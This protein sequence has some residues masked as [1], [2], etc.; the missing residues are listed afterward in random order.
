M[1]DIIILTLMIVILVISII[2]IKKI[3]HPIILI[4]IIFIFYGYLYDEITINTFDKFE[5]II[6]AII[7]FIM[8]IMSRIILVTI[9]KKNKKKIKDESKKSES[10]IL[11]L[12]ITSGIIFS[13]NMIFIMMGIFFKDFII[14]FK[15]FSNLLLNIGIFNEIIMLIHIDGE[16]KIK[17]NFILN[18]LFYN[19]FLGMYLNTI[20][21]IIGIAYIKLL[22]KNINKK[23]GWKIFMLVLIIFIIVKKIELTNTNNL[24]LL[25]D[26]STLHKYFIFIVVSFVYSLIF[27]LSSINS[28]LRVL[29]G[30]VIPSLGILFF[31]KIE[32]EIFDLIIKQVI[33]YYVVIGIIEF[34]IFLYKYREKKLKEVILE[35]ITINRRKI[36]IDAN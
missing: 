20:N 4:E 12:K 18:A 9:K 13:L 11:F 14:D 21:F 5:L 17:K 3:G 36:V 26:Y 6:G 35:V 15:N 34:R 31:I 29:L 24:Y 27:E 23:I 2:F 7:C 25:S 28:S 8:S 16:E 33:V 19:L 22:K 32:L 1:G 30:R 10:I